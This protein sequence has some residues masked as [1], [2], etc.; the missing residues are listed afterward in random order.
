[1][2]EQN[3]SS[4]E[5]EKELQAKLLVYRAL[6]SRMNTLAKQQ[7]M[8]ASKILEIQSTIES[9]DEIKKG[10]KEE[11]KDILFPLGSAAYTKGTVA[12]RNR[13]IVEVGAGVALEKTSDEAKMILEKRKKE[14]EGAIEV[15]QKELQSISVMMQK[16]EFD[17]QGIIQ[18]A[19]KEGG[20]FRVVSSE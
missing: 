12:D 16:I 10:E 11:A 18:Q 5:R 7:N 13:L 8:F 15:L 19:Q 2:N 17:T 6:E 9:I 1:M 20:K 4:G 14:L 3:L